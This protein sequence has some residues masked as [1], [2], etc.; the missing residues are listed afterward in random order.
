VRVC[1]L[2]NTR[3]SLSLAARASDTKVEVPDEIPAEARP[4]YL[5]LAAF[6]A[7]EVS[8]H[9]SLPGL[10]IT[11]NSIYASLAWITLSYAVLS[12]TLEKFTSDKIALLVGPVV[13][14]TQALNGIPRLYLTPWQTAT[15]AFG[16]LLINRLPKF[17][18]STYVWLASLVA[19]VWKNLTA[20]WTVAAFGLSAAYRVV[21]GLQDKRVPIQEVAFALLSAY[22][23]YTRDYAS[24]AVAIFAGYVLSSLFGAAQ[25]VASSLSDS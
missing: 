16:T 17:E 4:N 14:A 21:N 25:R 15:A 1:H 3:Q 20:E 11:L 12:W 8:K 5:A 18:Y 19:A 2:L 10:P 13:L 23:A 22:A 6:A 9:T 7:N 24:G